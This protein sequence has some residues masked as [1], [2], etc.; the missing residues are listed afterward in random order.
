[1]SISLQ[2]QLLCFENTTPSLVSI[3]VFD[4]VHLGHLHLI[5]KLKREASERRMKSIILTFNQ[6]PLSVIPGQK[7][8]PYLTTLE[9]KLDLLRKPGIDNVINIDF[10]AEIAKMSA[11]DFSSHLIKSLGMKGLVIGSDFALGRN[12]EGEIPKLIEIGNELGFSVDAT[13]SVKIDNEIISSTAIRTALSMGNVAK[14]TRML[15]RP[16]QLSGYAIRGEGRGVALGFPTAN[17]ELDSAQSLPA[18]G[19]YA[20]IVHIGNI[21]YLSATNIGFRPTFGDKKHL[22][23]VHI[24]DFDDSIYEQHLKI[25]IIERIRGE[26][27]FDTID[28]LKEQI[29]EDIEETNRILCRYTHGNQ[30]KR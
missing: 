8:L 22:A 24:I 13:S 6:H 2:K 25:D 18:D 19:V 12:R 11:H 21:R 30:T 16:F 4:G 27:K 28:E 29:R 5:N 20:S 3:G 1:V 17:L 26:I 15:G 23:E 14:A 10:T 9:D 7:D